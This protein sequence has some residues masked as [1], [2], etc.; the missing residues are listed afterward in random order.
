MPKPTPT[1]DMEAA[2]AALCEGQDL[3]GK[4]GVLTPLI[5]QLTE[6]AMQAELDSHLSQEEAP[7]RKNGSSSKT[8]K[9]TAGSSSP[10]ETALAPLSLSS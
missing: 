9:S 3:T 8:V 4:D 7:N 10:R 5:K 6:A 1:F 2:I